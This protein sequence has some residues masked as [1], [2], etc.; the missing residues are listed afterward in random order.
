MIGQGVLLQMFE[1]DTRALR[2]FM[3]EDGNRSH[4]VRAGASRPVVEK[5]SM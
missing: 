2:G 5:T 3:L 4:E 1:Q